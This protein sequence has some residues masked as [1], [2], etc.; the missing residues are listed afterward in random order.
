MS[1]TRVQA[2]R[3][4]DLKRVAEI[5][6]D[7]RYSLRCQHCGSSQPVSREAIADWP[8]CCGTP[9][10]LISPTGRANADPG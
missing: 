7:G 2:D 1:L 3:P 8:E 6:L 5:L 9:M 10:M 4:S